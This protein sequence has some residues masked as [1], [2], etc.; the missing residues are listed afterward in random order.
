MRLV[1]LPM[2]GLSQARGEATEGREWIQRCSDFLEK[3]R[4]WAVPQHPSHFQGWSYMASASPAPTV[5]G[6]HPFPEALQ[7]GKEGPLHMSS[8]MAWPAAA[9][10]PLP[11]CKVPAL[12][13]SA[14]PR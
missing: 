4:V 8:P 11:A 9:P 1:P 14:Q 10:A 3:E 5:L 13:H 12:A 7:E 6:L 2:R